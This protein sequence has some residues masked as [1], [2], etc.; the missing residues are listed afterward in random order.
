MLYKSIAPFTQGVDLQ[1]RPQAIDAAAF[2]I[3]EQLRVHRGVVFNFPGWSSILAS[4]AVG[5]FGTM[6]H[7]FTSLSGASTLL[8]AGPDKVYTYSPITKTVTDVSGALTFNATRTDPWWPFFFNDSLYFTQKNDGLNK[9]GGGTVTAIPSAPKA[10]VGGVIAAHL[11]LFNVNDGTDHPQ[12]FQWASEATDND[13]VEA[14]NNDAGAFD[15]VEGGDIGIG[16]LPIQDDMVLYKEQAIIQIAFIGGNEVFGRRYS[17]HNVGLLGTYAV[18]DIGGEHIFMGH[19]TFYRYSGGNVTDDVGLKIKD[20]VYPIMNF[21]RRARIR[22]VYIQQTREVLFMFPSILNPEQPDADKCVIYNVHD[23]A[24]YGPFDIRCSMAGV[25]TR[26]SAIVVDDV[27]DIVDEVSII[28]NQ[29]PTGVAE[30][31]RTLFTDDVGNLMEIGLAQS[32]NG[33][34]ITRTMESGDQYLG[35]MTT[36][37][38]GAPSAILP[39]AVFQVAEVNLEFNYLEPNKRY[40]LWVGF[41]MSLQTPIQY[42][43]PFGIRGSQTS[44]R[45]KQPMRVTGRWFRVRIVIPSSRRMVLA[46]YQYGYN[47]VGRR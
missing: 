31:P 1:A 41:R 23:Q 37:Q 17:I 4:G 13:W 16:A 21:T 43:G 20:R 18:Q 40:D 33:E 26:D 15:I 29:Y 27:T 46:G 12:R 11:C 35:A 8:V 25:T 30:Q 10:R 9:W 38:N 14:P 24:W 45:I 6:I 42:A 28:V 32:A 2:L 3:L 39:E 19:D 34:P 22:S 5:A 47:V 36:D 7:E 44:G